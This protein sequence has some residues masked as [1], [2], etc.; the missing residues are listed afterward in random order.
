LT[1][2][3]INSS[4]MNHL[5]LLT[6]ALLLV[7]MTN[8]SAQ[9]SPFQKQTLPALWDLKELVS[10]PNNG[11]S[12]KD[13]QKNID[14]LST[15]FQKRGFKT[16]P[17]P[18]KGNPLLLAEKVVAANLPTILFYMHLD[19]QPVDAS[20]W[21]QAD[22]YRAVL[23]KADKNGDWQTVSWDK[24]DQ[25][26]DPSWRIFGRSAADDKGPIIGFLHAM[27]LLQKEGKQPV[28]NI[29]V[30]LDSEEEMGSKYLAEAV[31][32][33]EDLLK[34]DV[35]II[36]DGP[37]HISGQPTLI[38]GCRGI[39][40][41]NLTV[42]GAS[43]PQHS[44]HYGNYAPNPNFM[45]AHLL[46][47]MKDQTGK[48]LIEGYYDGI[49][50]DKAAAA[51]MAAVP[52]NK[53]DILNLLQIAKPE[54]VGT[55]Y[56]E[57]LQFPSLNVRGMASA[58]VGSQA[59]TIVP[60]NSTAAIDIRLVPE[61]D[62]KRLV[63]L[64]KKHIE[65]Q[66]YHIV[67]KEPTT[68]ERLKYP[69]ICYFYAGGATL[70]FRTDLNAPAGKWLE[71]AIQQQYQQAPVKVRIMG[72]TVPISSFINQL[73]IPAIIVP[74]VNSDNNQHSPNENFRI[75]Y[76]TNSIKTFHGILTTRY[77]FE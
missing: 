74:M 38:F 16:Q 53:T 55:N 35:L 76:L 10:I 21:N 39:T 68:E 29:K 64:I 63:S 42:Y 18:N 40:T 59:R 32:E 1:N 13:I 14:W 33:Y 37:V 9:E 67:T 22:P 7:L 34:A 19:G 15:A 46:A 2:Y 71:K 8:L 30:I 17:L 61:S 47:S 70:P 4:K 72:G 26:V 20:K 23:K 48:V 77:M 60:S 28:F 57:A 66:G 52:D 62:P 69:K 75:D 56:Q 31:A 58:W 45:M 43:K 49:E 44:G 27:D 24:V 41:V 11:L 6:I 36:N 51:T 73:N 5:R 50:W 12:P 65:K 54:Q 25:T 3:Q